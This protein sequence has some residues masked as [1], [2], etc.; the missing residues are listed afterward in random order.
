MR[1]RAQFVTEMRMLREKMVGWSYI[2]EKELSGEEVYDR[3]TCGGVY[4]RRLTPHKSGTKRK[5]LC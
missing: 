1:T 3:A 2:K 4:R 5:K